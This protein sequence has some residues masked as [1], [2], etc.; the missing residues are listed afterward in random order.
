MH[1]DFRAMILQLSLLSRYVNE[2]QLK[3]MS[4]YDQY[5]LRS[6]RNKQTFLYSIPST[7][8]WRQKS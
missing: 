8:Q 6:K 1:V 3:R 5:N 4:L 7:K 2:Y